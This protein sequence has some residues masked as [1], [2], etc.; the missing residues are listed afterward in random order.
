MIDL[1]RL[2]SATLRHAPY[3][4]AV[5]ADLL[6][7]TEAKTLCRDL[8]TDGFHLDTKSGAG[9]EKRYR[10]YNLGLVA[11]GVPR[12]PAWDALAPSWR[13]FAGELIGAPYRAAL[14]AAAGLSLDD[15]VVEV[16]L[17]RYAAG[18]WMDPHTDRPDKKLTQIIY[19]NPDWDPEWGG[20]L[21]ILRSASSTDI[22]ATV[23]PVLGTSVLLRPSRSSWHAVAP[24]V[25]HVDAQRHSVLLHYSLAS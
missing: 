7:E 16:R 21:L 22:A 4:V 25:D 8:P 15:C 18:C 1:M 3:D 11:D 2:R 14:G 20:N 24:V 13:R 12:Q 9:A 17:C 5:V 10:S 23:P 6:D 19:L